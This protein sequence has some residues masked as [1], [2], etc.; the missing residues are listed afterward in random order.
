MSMKKLM[1]LMLAVVLMLAA[2]AG[3][4]EEPAADSLGN[5]QKLDAVYM[6]A[7]NA[8][9]KEDYAT[10]QK[11]LNICFVYCDPETDPEVYSDLLLKQACINV[12]DEEYNIALLGLDAALE[13]SPELADA[14]LVRTQIYSAQGDLDNAVTNL[15]KYIELS[16][17]DSLFETVAQLYE[18]SGNME[19]AQAA[20]DKFAE[21][22][23]A[24]NQDVGFQ[25]ALYR[26]QNGKYDEAIKAFEAYAEDETY[27][28]GAQY[29]I[30]VCKMNSGDIAGAAEAFTACEKKGGTYDGLY[31][32]R[33]YCYLL[34]KE[35]AKGAE[36][37]TR[38][39]E[40]ESFKEDARYNLGICHMEQGEYEAAVAAFDELVNAFEG[41][42]EVTLNDAVYYF[43]AMC[44]SALGKLEDAIRDFTTCIDHE[45]ELAQCYYERAQ[46]YA[47]MGD[48]EKQSGDLENALKY[49]K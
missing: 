20:Y 34:N 31:Y 48:T 5:G 32:N 25:A 30:A 18:A 46:V 41:N 49:A 39:I 37:F 12:I 42:E 40:T 28:A 3:I 6:L 22:A 15:E 45:Y 26:M 4:A 17:D 7:L 29:N 14:Y 44:N 13:L 43:R 21:T 2:A 27:G 38:S 23:G 24:D 11:Y 9:N 36:D 47:A 33:G 10:A 16:Q 35:W 8:I 19:A 1:S